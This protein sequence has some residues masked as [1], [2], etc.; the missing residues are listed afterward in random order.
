MTNK[1]DTNRTIAQLTLNYYE[2]NTMAHEARQSLE[3]ACRAW[4]IAN[5]LQNK[6]ERDT[7][8]W[9]QM[10]AATELEN[11]HWQRMKTRRNHVHAQLMRKAATALKVHSRRWSSTPAEGEK[12]RKLALIELQKAI[13]GPEKQ[14]ALDKRR[15]EAA[16]SA[17]GVSRKAAAQVCRDF[18]E[19][20]IEKR[21]A[22]V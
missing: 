4:A 15:L 12:R 19:S 1:N 20:H 2:A 14:R 6:P 7:P 13:A 5:G 11:A 10:C 8:E 16:L 9:E 3:I 22:H 17:I 18:F 21:G